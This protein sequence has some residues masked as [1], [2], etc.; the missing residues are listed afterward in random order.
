VEQFVE[1]PRAD[2]YDALRALPGRLATES[3]GVIFR[4]SYFRRV[5]QPGPG[6]LA[7]HLLSRAVSWGQT[8]GEGVRV[9][10]TLLPND[11]R[12]EDFGVPGRKLQAYHAGDPRFD[13][14]NGM[15]CIGRSSQLRT[16]LC[17]NTLVI[18]DKLPIRLYGLKDL[19]SLIQ[20]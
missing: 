3:G 8:S 1:K 12:F 2:Q 6:N 11:I 7:E 15:T 20:T 17:S 19:W 13:L 10:T 14:G 4:E 18:A 16:L 5:V 9:A